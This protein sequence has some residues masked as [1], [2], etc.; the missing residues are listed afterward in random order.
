MSSGARQTKKD[1]A[2]EHI[3]DSNATIEERI[4]S[5]GFYDITSD[6]IKQIIEPR[7]AC[8]IDHR[9]DN[10]VPLVSR[11]LSILAIK[12]GLYRIAATDV[13]VDLPAFP[14]SKVGYVKEF[15]IPSHVQVLG[16]DSLS[17]ESKALDAAL[18]S[19]MLDYVFEDSVVLVLRGREYSSNLNFRLSSN[20]PRMDHLD[21]Q[22]ESVQI[23]VDG[24]YEGQRGIYLVEAKNKTH[25]VDNLTIRQLLYPQL[26]YSKKFGRTKPVHTFVLLHNPVTSLFHFAK[27][28]VPI[29]ERFDA[30]HV[31]DTSEYITCKLRQ[32]QDVHRDYWS[33]LLT[34][35]I[36]DSVVDADRPFPQADSFDRIFALFNQLAQVKRSLK[37]QLFDAHGLDPRQHDY[38][39]N[40]LRWLKLADFDSHS[41]M[42][43]LTRKGQ[44]I[45]NIDN[46]KDIYFE[47]ARIALSNSLFNKILHGKENQI[48]EHD[49]TMNRLYSESTFYRRLQTVKSWI[50]YFEDSLKN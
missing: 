42:F 46:P 40:A 14:H 37:D 25:D 7:I 21:Y 28:N 34:C 22:L 24:G 1:K 39:G 35:R 29:R 50:R 27:F 36:D 43:E 23:E 4:A 12:N 49:R 13:F 44:A 32:E 8:K 30:T 17:S 41:Q 38:Y 3:F 10:P 19:G 31:F 48:S 45:A 47:I 2:W 33:E 16:S 5:D 20:H 26:N 15:E 18:V 11:G 6:E 9:Q